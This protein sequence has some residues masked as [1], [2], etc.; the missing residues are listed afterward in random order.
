MDDG[1]SFKIFGEDKY[2]SISFLT[3]NDEEENY[4]KNNY[5]LEKN[6][7]LHIKDYEIYGF[8]KNSK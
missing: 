2:L 5:K 3:N 4:V 6:N 1:F 7:F 8:K